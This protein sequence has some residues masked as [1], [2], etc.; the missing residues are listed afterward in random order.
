MPLFV[1]A[2]IW[3]MMA[4]AWKVFTDGIESAPIFDSILAFFGPVWVFPAVAG[5]LLLNSIFLWSGI[6]VF[7]FLTSKFREIVRGKVPRRPFLL[8]S[9]VFLPIYGA[10]F[11][12][13]NLYWYSFFPNARLAT[14]PLGQIAD[15]RMLADV[16][17][18]PYFIALVCALWGTAPRS[19]RRFQQFAGESPAIGTLAQSD[20]LALVENAD[21]STLRR[22]LGFMVGAGLLNALIM[23]F[24]LGRLSAASHGSTVAGLM[25]R[26]IAYVA[27]GMAAGA[28]GAWLYWKRPASPFREHSPLPFPLFALICAAGWVWVPAIVLFS[29]QDSAA[30]SLVSMIGA[31]ALASGLR[32]ATY[33]TLLPDQ[34]GL[35]MAE[36]GPAELF[37]EPLY[38]SPI[39]TYG[40]VI[41]I[42]LYGA[43]AALLNGNHFTADALVALSAAVFAWKGT[44][45]RCQSLES[46]D[47][48]KRPAVRLALFLIPAV[49]VTF[50]ALL[51]GEAHG[52]GGAEM[53]S[54]LDAEGATAAN[55]NTR[56]KARPESGHGIS[57]YESI[58][59]W[60]VPEKKQII[61]PL[62]AQSN[63]LA[64]GT[65]KPLVIRFDAPYLYFQ[66]PSKG[67]GPR[68][69]Q[70]HGSPLGGD[71][72]A[73]NFFPLIMEAH[74]S[75][76]GSIRVVR[77][78]EMDV[79]ILNRDNRRGILNLAVLLTDTASPGKST[80]YLG[81]QP[82][83]TSEPDHFSVKSRPVTEVLRFPIS[84]PAK[85]GKFDEITVMF[86]PDGENFQLGPKIAVQDFELLPR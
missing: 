61:P 47:E 19:I 62:P 70:T 81:Q 48:Y 51:D 54:A 14:T 32:R 35:S 57:G 31:F 25:T 84:I 86:L 69:Y 71:I 72:Q 60:P 49:M 50:W 37:S 11:L 17:R 38:R 53:S 63:L 85:I 28:G 58:I 12:F 67:P 44:V 1:F 20:A 39:E 73:N 68:A 56:Q 55:Q 3:T 16:M 18:I 34:H 78:R 9:L 27:A 21:P 29:D 23:A 52:N 75:L 7:I 40:Y 4:P 45:P 64:P 42:C 76:G 83:V 22:F 65:S 77:C 79:T 66:K 43:G 24:V 26:A 6:F 74:Q 80:L 36:R 59:L 46:G 82:V 30:A 33:F 5:W 15:L 2:L 10:T 41:A 13:G 8:A